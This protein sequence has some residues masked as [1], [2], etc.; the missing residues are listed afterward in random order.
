MNVAR[1]LGG[2]LLASLVMGMVEMVSEAAAGPG[3]WSP[4]VFI[5]ATVLRPLQSVPTPVPFM[6]LPVALGTM[7]HMMN[8]IILGFVF[9]LIFSRFAI[10]RG[11]LVGAGV[12]YALLIFA[13]TWYLV[14][15]VIDPVMLKLNPASFAVAH[16]MWGA[17]LGLTMPE[18]T[19]RA[20]RLTA[21]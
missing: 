19:Q 13:M 2:R 6:A 17:A 11:A 1:V 5:A 15:P 12:G 14:L 3:F 9:G 21:A 4:L 20:G 7:G 18:H 16:V 8:S 10:G